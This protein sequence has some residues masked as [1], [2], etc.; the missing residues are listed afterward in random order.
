MLTL[1]VPVVIAEMGWITMGTVDILMVRSLGPAAIGAVGVGSMLFMAVAVL[2][3]ACSW[4]ST[5]LS[6]KHTERAGVTSV[7]VGFCTAS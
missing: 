6:P 1:A 4:G 2:A 3:S 5:P 7:T